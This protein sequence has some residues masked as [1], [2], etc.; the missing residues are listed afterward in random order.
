[1]GLSDPCTDYT[2]NYYS[3]TWKCNKQPY[4]VSQKI[5]KGLTQWAIVLLGPNI[6]KTIDK[7]ENKTKT[8]RYNTKNLQEINPIVL[9]VPWAYTNLDNY[10]I[11]KLEETPWRRSIY[12]WRQVQ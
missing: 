9:C 12:W 7:H 2:N 3:Q 8:L 4:D 5:H 1:M 10:K 11:E 6:L